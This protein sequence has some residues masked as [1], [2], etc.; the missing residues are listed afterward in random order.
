[1]LNACQST[2]YKSG[3]GPLRSNVNQLCSIFNCFLVLDKMW[4]F[5]P[6]HCFSHRNWDQYLAFTFK[7]VMSLCPNLTSNC[8]RFLKWHWA[9]K[10]CDRAVPGSEPLNGRRLVSSFTPL[11][12]FCSAHAKVQALNAP[13]N[14]KYRFSYHK[15]ACLWRQKWLNEIS[16]SQWF[17]FFFACKG[18]QS[19][20]SKL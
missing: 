11:E 13:K 7:N 18:H 4:I 16:R 2:P 20:R 1:M 15:H 19:S 12:R 9:V 6:V 5:C 8:G 17:L 14:N 3:T 10:R